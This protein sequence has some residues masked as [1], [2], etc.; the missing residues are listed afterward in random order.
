MTWRTPAS[1]NLPLSSS[2][3]GA[4]PASLSL[5]VFL[6]L[7]S[8]FSIL[9]LDFVGSGVHNVP[10]MTLIAVLLSVSLQDTKTVVRQEKTEYNATVAKFKDAEALVESDPQAAIERLTEILSNAKLRFFEC[11]LKIEQRPGDYTEHSFLPY[12]ARG[13]ARVNL[14]K[15]ATPEAAQKLLADAVADFTESVK[16]NVA[17]SADPLKSAQT[18]LAKL[19]ADAT[20]L[21]DPVK[22]DP[23][24]KFREKWI[25]LMEAKRYKAARTLIEKDSEGLT[26]EDRKNYLQNAEQA[27]RAQLTNWVSD[28]RPRFLGAVGLGLDQKTTEE[29]DLL[30]TL[31]ASEEL[32]V[33]HP[34]VDWVRQFE[35]TFRNVQAQK[36]PAYSLAAA[37]A[38][39]APLEDRFENPWFKAIEQSV[40]QSLKNGISGEV[41]N[42]RDASKADREKARKNADAL[43]AEWKKF[44]GKLEAKFVER[45]RFVADHEGQLTKLFDGFPADLADLDK[46]D[47]SVEGAF[48]ADAPDAELAKVEESIAQLESK[49]NLTVETRQRLY[50]ARVTVAALRGLFNGKTEDA[51]AADLSGYKAKLRDVGGPGDVKKFGPRV[52]RVFAALR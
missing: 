2:S 39:A 6:I 14:S 43:L 7:Y 15:K 8:L 30:F 33:S 3:F 4:R 9:I 19:K 46:V 13:Q 20:K 31:P 21:P 34:A 16:R 48:V 51:V 41:G 24:A 10:M 32:I 17:S 27:C 40:F 29:F 50:T 28:F 25:P 36:A 26:D 12:Q 5:V 52:E 22:S 1:A 42:A 23:V 37:A 35:P 44:T 18:T 11:V 45:H 49:G 47:Q 38:A